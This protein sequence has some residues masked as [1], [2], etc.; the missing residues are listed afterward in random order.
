VAQDLQVRLMI[1]ARHRAIRAHEG[2]D[3]VDLEPQ[4]MAGVATPLDRVAADGPR[5]EAAT[6]ADEAGSTPGGPSGRE[7]DVVPL[8]LAGVPVA[9][10]RRPSRRER[11]A[12]T[13]DAAERLA[14]IDARDVHPPYDRVGHRWR[15]SSAMEPGRRHPAAKSQRSTR[16][17][18]TTVGGIPSRTEVA[19][20][21]IRLGAGR[22]DAVRQGIAVSRIVTF[23]V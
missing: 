22:V 19:A 23:V 12:T 13:F 4:L 18:R 10:V 3:V 20:A 17:I 11:L 15:P 7:P 2:R 5:V 9:A 1:T 16:T 14:D 6:L 8:E 21:A